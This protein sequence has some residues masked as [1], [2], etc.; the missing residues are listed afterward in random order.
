VALDNIHRVLQPPPL[1]EYYHHP[2]GN[3]VPT[4]SHQM[5]FDKNMWLAPQ[6]PTK[7]KSICVSSL[8]RILE[9]SCRNSDV[10]APE[11][12]QGSVLKG[13]SDSVGGKGWQVWSGVRV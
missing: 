5:N 10:A 2:T 4:H 13:A 6:P 3:P 1:L 9:Q 7:I 12:N 8:K 11:Q